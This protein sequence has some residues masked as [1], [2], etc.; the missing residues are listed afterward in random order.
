MWHW[1]SNSK[2]ADSQGNEVGHKKTSLELGLWHIDQLFK[3][4]MY[5]KV[6]IFTGFNAYTGKSIK[7]TAQK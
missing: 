2:D 5:D 3:C 6:E 1:Q 4:H 7:L